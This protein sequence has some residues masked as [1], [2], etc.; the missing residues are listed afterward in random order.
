VNS[1]IKVAIVLILK[2]GKYF[3]QLRG[4]DPYKG[5]AGLIGGFGGKI[6]PNETAV[7]AAKRELEEETTLRI[8]SKRLRNLGSVTV[9]SDY[10]LKSTEVHLTAFLLQ[11]ESSETFAAT[12]G[13]V[14]KLTKAEAIV[15]GE[16]M[17]PG[18]LACFKKIVKE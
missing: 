12:E 9:V 13:S 17:T 8:S 3:L 6:E 7:Q 2:D 18:T 16:T 15:Q 14:V 4:D 11:L 5:A 1:I 10:Q